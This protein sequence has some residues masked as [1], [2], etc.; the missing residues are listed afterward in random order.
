MPRRYRLGIPA[1]LIVGVYVVA[2]AVAAVIAMTTGDLGGLWRLTLFTEVDE[3]AAA[4]WPSVLTLLLAGMAWAWALWQS[5]RGPMAGPPPE[6]DRHTRR[7]RMALYATAASWLLNPL[8][9]SWPHWALVLDAVLMCVVVVLFQPVLRR[10]LEHAD[11]ALGAGV[12]GYGGSAVITVIDVPDGLLP[13]GVGLICALAALVWMVLI[14]RAQRWDGRWRRA[15]FVYG[16]TSMVAPIVMALVGPL[17]AAAGGLYDVLA[18]TGALTV[19]WLT[20]SA[21]ELADPRHQPAPPT[22]LAEQPPTP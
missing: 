16:I 12:L 20:R 21:H 3:D 6:L 5:L 2:L 14:L 7:L 4:T 15:T 22:P 11:F 1:L 18:A 10:S 19:I 17:L 8:V 13:S 9:P